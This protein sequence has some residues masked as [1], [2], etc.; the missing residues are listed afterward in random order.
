MR[1]TEMDGGVIYLFFPH[2]SLIFGIGIKKRRMQENR[3]CR[4][5]ESSGLE[6]QKCSGAL[7]MSPTLY[8]LLHF[9]FLFPVQDLGGVKSCTLTG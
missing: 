7:L 6:R 3:K 2:S 4:G 9:L 1:L 5:E 8:S